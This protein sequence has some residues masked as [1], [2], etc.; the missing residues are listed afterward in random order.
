MSATVE[1][2]TA[3]ESAIAVK[4]ATAVKTSSATNN[5]RSAETMGDIATT[6][7]TS[8][9]IAPARTA[10]PSAAPVSGIAPIPVIPRT[11]A[12]KHTTYKPARTV[13]AVRRAGIRIIRVISV[14]THWRPGHV[15]RPDSK[16]Y[17]HSYLR[18]R[19]GKGQHK[20]CQQREIFQV[21]HNH[22]RA[23]GAQ[24]FRLDPK[25]LSNLCLSERG[26]RRKVAGTA[27]AD[28]GHPG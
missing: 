25:A 8:R 15:A 19:I 24:I 16:A 13:V 12:D 21:P 10:V 14:C 1:S 7:K 27:V 3:V 17:P 20:D 5:R 6:S 22:L 28:F 26:S 23:S 4:T 2:A 11:R 18:L 9:S